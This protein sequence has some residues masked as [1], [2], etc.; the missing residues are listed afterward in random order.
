M[1]EIDRQILR[2]LQRDGRMT[3]QQLGDEVGLSASPCARRV[4]LLEEAGII[5]GYAADDRRGAAS[6]FGV[7]VLVS[8][9]LDRQVDDAL[10]K[11]L[12]Q[13]SNSYPEVVDCWLMTG[14]A[15]LPDHGSR[16][17][18]SGGVRRDF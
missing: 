1:D 9:K 5:K 4:R 8:V 2:S 16:R 7:S 14:D 3:M 18:R 13:R 12:K 6:V 17:L 15:R 11:S 10:K